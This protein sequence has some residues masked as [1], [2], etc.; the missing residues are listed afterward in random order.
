MS[1]L[2]LFAFDPDYIPNNSVDGKLKVT[3]GCYTITELMRT[4][5]LVDACHLL[6]YSLTSSV[7][8]SWTDAR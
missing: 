8:Y 7:I 6:E 1:Y 5:W 3:I 2:Y 4:L